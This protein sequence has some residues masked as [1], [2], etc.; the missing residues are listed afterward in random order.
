MDTV[1]RNDPFSRFYFA[2]GAAGGDPSAHAVIER[3]LHVDV[4]ARLDEWEEKVGL[5]WREHVDDAVELQRSRTLA[6][7]AAA[8]DAVAIRAAI[9][10]SPDPYHAADRLLLEWELTRA[11]ASRGDDSYL[12]WF[13]PVGVPVVLILL[14][15]A[16]PWAVHACI[17]SFYDASG[18]GQDLVVAAARRWHERYGAEPVALW[19]TM[20]QMV[21]SRPPAEVTDAWPLARAPGF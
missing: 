16:E 21:V 8:P 15:V 3:A 19:G 11:P 14:P 18:Y 7:C 5:Y 2:E 13:E 12:S 9:A 17:S 4:D 1:V 20:I 10:S 6:L